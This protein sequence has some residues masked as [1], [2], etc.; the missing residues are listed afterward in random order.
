MPFRLS[1]EWEQKRQER[2]LLKQVIYEDK[3]HHV[4]TFM[5]RS[6]TPPML[7]KMRMNSYARDDIFPKLTTETLLDRAKYYQSQCS[8]P[9][10]PC[11]TYNESLIHK[12]V[13]ELIKRLEEAENGK[14]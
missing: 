3:E 7:E 4:T 6:I 8:T 10:F 13:P 2:E 5:D 9:R 11:S 12:I 1:P 14:V